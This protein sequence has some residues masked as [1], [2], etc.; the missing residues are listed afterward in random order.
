MDSDTDNAVLVLEHVLQQHLDERIL[1]PLTLA[2][3]VSTHVPVVF[4]LPESLLPKVDTIY[5]ELLADFGNA[6]RGIRYESVCSREMLRELITRS[7]LVLTDDPE[8]ARVAAGLRLPA[9]AL[10]RNKSNLTAELRNLERL[11]NDRL[12]QDLAGWVQLLN[13]ATQSGSGWRRSLLGPRTRRST[14]TE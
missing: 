9:L 7:C 1:L 5:D 10:C 2:Y 3:L 11:S 12:R 13:V 8:T 4:P 14:L 6:S